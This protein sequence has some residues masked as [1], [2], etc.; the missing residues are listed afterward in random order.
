MRF[1][2]SGAIDAAALV[3]VALQLVSDSPEDARSAFYA[4]SLACDPLS[5]ADGLVHA[6]AEQPVEVKAVLL[7]HARWLVGVAAHVPVLRV[8]LV[9]LGVVG[10]PTDL[11]ILRLVGRH[12]A[13]T[14]YAGVA[15]TAIAL[16]TG[17]DPAD[18]WWA[19]ARAARGWGKIHAVERLSLLAA[20]RPE[21]RDWL[22]REGC[23]NKVMN[24]Y[25]AYDCAIAG[26]LEAALA[27]PTIDRALLDGACTIVHAL[28][29]G[30]PARDIADYDGG[31]RV[32]ADLIR[33]LAAQA[34]TLSHLHTVRAMERWLRGQSRALAGTSASATRRQ[35]QS[36]RSIEGQQRYTAKLRERGWTSDV[37]GELAEECRSIL[38]QPRWRAAVRAG[39][40][41]DDPYEHWLAWDLGPAVGLDLWEDEFARLRAQPGDD[42]YYVRL[43]STRDPG[44]FL[45]LVRFAE[46][47]LPLERVGTGPANAIFE[48]EEPAS[49]A[50]GWLVQEMA[51]RTP[52]SP[53]L[54]AA[55]LRSPVIWMRNTALRALAGHPP[56][57][58][59]EP[60]RAALERSAV[61][62]LDPELRSR[63]HDHL[64]QATDPGVGQADGPQS[65]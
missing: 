58:W 43:V 50:V 49:Q 54:V 45:R 7:P 33:H 11:P 21:I 16:R 53:P 23:A 57:N 3:R 35:E 41:N 6:L 25:L 62:E 9:L 30:G 64:R 22:L 24:E 31:I 48:R 51:Q 37:C 28:L 55:A 4:A 27:T 5:I 47:S 60:V 56:A 42:K 17:T 44:R 18:E 19:L 12:D 52:F 61:D 39:F 14:L 65:R 46:E 29:V 2:S 38:V 13:F 32:V 15:A 1:E 36:Q 59:G 63:I 10:T 20:D 8:G 40:D 34:A 26:R